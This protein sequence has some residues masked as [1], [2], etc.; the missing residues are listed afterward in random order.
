MFIFITI[1]VNIRAQKKALVES[2]A[3][4]LSQGEEIIHSVLQLEEY[5]DLWSNPAIFLHIVSVFL[6]F[7]CKVNIFKEASIQTRLTLR[8]SVFKAS[9]SMMIKPTRKSSNNNGWRS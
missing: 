5:L 9:K 3:E 8:S 2:R 7:G 1:K 6:T 4:P